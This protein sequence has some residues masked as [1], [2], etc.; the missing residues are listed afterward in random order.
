V[1]LIKICDKCLMEVH[2]AS[3]EVGR[4][5]FSLY[6]SD[7]H[8]SVRFEPFHHEV[9]IVKKK[10]LEEMR[11]EEQ[12]RAHLIGSLSLSLSLPPSLLTL[13]PL[14]PLPLSG[15]ISL[16]RVRRRVK[17][18]S[19]RAL[20]CQREGYLR[21]E[22]HRRDLEEQQRQEE[23]KQQQLQSRNH[24]IHTALA[25]DK[26]WLQQEKGAQLI[27]SQYKSD[28][29]ELK[30]YPKF[31]RDNPM[32]PLREH[33]H[34][35]KLV[36][37]GGKDGNMPIDRD[38]ASKVSLFLSISRSP[39]LDTSFSSSLSLLILASNAHR[40]S[41]PPPYLRDSVQEK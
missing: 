15:Q 9:G 14:P 41:L 39:L 36:S 6:L 24:M 22:Q 18:W 19:I 32:K 3:S 2:A 27:R 23:L 12:R 33:P 28:L 40:S 1:D 17:E 29:V 7:L 34:S 38:A 5:S 10:H 31:S 25:T 21:E 30:T 26:Y 35:W 4:Y 8:P 13:P 37:Y 20:K 11:D 16:E